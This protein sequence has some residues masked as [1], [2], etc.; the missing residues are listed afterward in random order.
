MRALIIAC[1]LAACSPP[2]GSGEEDQGEAQVSEAHASAGPCP[3]NE[4]LNTSSRV[5]EEIRSAIQVDLFEFV[6]CQ[7][8]G[9]PMEGR[10]S[11]QGYSADGRYYELD[12]EFDRYWYV[13]EFLLHLAWDDVPAEVRAASAEASPVA[14]TP[15]RVV[16]GTG[17]N[18]P[19]YY[20]LFSNSELVQVIAVSGN[21][22]RL[23]PVAEDRARCRRYEQAGMHRGIL[24]GG[25]CSLHPR[26]HLLGPP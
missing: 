16:R 24:R 22:A 20:G 15:T 7:G 26:F 6:V 13:S 25:G 23:R 4:S 14:F 17:T 21:S 19:T 5:P 10:Y 8:A 18:L 12:L 2:S 11:V 1:L 3:Q 9:D